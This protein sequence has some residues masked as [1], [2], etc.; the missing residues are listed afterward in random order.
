MSLSPDFRFLEVAYPYVAKRL[1]TDRDASLRDRLTQVLFDK[2]GTFSWRRLENLV[3]LARESG[4]G[5]DLT[6]TVA[7]G[8]QLLITDEALRRQLLLALT[9]DNRLRVDEVARVAALLGEDIA[10]DRLAQQ[11][12]TG[13]PAFLRKMALS[14]S[15]KVLSN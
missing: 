3:A 14:W 13:G 9:E 5:L 12:L 11:S 15:D 1:L 4:G 2:D 7:D 8:A 6:D 10:V